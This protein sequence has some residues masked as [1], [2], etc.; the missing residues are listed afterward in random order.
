MDLPDSIKDLVTDE[1]Y[2]TDDIGR[3]GSSIQIYADKILK[4]QEHNEESGNEYRMMQYLQGKLPVPEVYAYETAGRLSYLLMSK[5]PGQMACAREYMTDPL[6]QCRML[7]DG[8]KRLWSVDISDCP[9]DQRLAHKLE[10][11]GYNV[12]NNLVDLDNVEPDTFGERG[13]Q[14]PA[15]LLQWLY[16]NRPD[17][18]PVLSHGD[19]CLPNI[20]GMGERVSGYIDLGKTGIADKWCDIAICYRSLSHN[21]N[22]KYHVETVPNGD[23]FPHWEEY[24]GYDGTLL[25][26]ELG[27]EPDWEKIRYYLLLDE[28]F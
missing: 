23:M 4:V 1:V 6:T 2:K 17:E 21:Y 28:L 11:A 14:D 12:E 22:G 9:S 8:L 25:F 16:D 18:E 5:C 15:A 26:R 20:F 10:Q 27:M 19:Y 24:P 3:S 7:A 13:F